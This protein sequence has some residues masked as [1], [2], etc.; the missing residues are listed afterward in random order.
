[1]IKFMQKYKE[2]MKTLSMDLILKLL[3]EKDDFLLRKLIPVAFRNFSQL[4][5]LLGSLQSNL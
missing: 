1:M 2:G 5:H 3:V 4:D